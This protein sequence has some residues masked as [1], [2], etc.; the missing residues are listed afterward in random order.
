MLVLTS[1]RRTKQGVDMQIKKSIWLLTIV[2]LGTACAAGAE[3]GEEC[4]ADADC[5]EGLECKLHDGEEDHGECE[6]H[7]DEDHSEEDHSEEGEAE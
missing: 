3:V 7:S 1:K 6:E 5:A 4:S 2:L